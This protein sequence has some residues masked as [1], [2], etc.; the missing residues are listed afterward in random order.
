[1]VSNWTQIRDVV[2]FYFAFFKPLVQVRNRQLQFFIFATCSAKEA[3]TWDSF[4]FLLPNPSEPS[5]EVWYLR[6]FD[7]HPCVHLLDP[8]SFEHLDFRGR[9]LV[10]ARR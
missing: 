7:E 6:L 4:S 10:K 2:E 3:E 5:L 1:M 8:F 9:L